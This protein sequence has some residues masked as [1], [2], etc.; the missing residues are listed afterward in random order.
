MG[1]KHITRQYVHCDPIFI[2]KESQIEYGSEY[3]HEWSPGGGIVGNNSLPPIC[4]FQSSP[5]EHI[6]MIPCKQ[7][8]KMKTNEEE[9]DCLQRD[10]MQARKKIKRLQSKHKISKSTTIREPLHT[11][12]EISHTP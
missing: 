10:T 11:G 7:T 8:N 3:S 9:R 5:H 6:H 4:S 1:K 2:K 12:P